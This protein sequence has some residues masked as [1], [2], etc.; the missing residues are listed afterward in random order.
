M[1]RVVLT[2]INIEVRLRK[3]VYIMKDETVKVVHF[4]NFVESGIHY[5]ALI[6]TPIILLELIK[7][8]KT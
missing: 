7:V 8:R 1:C 3:H 4:S 6:E 2:L 5:S